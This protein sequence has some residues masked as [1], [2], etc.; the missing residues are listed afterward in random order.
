MSGGKLTSDGI[1][2]RAPWVC[3]LACVCLLGT[4]CVNRR[5]TIR[6]NPPGALVRINGKDAGYTPLSRDFTHYGTYEVSLV[7]DGF[8]TE[9]LYWDVNAPW[10]QVPPLD[11]VSDNLLPFRLTNRHELVRNLTVKQI[12]PEGELSSRAKGLRSQALIGN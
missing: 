6:S 1:V 12:V 8:E 3:V 10:Y 7:K 11:F 9:S 4:G 5:M 2:A